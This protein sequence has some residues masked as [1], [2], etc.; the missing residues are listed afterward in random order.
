MSQL[1]SKY[2]G[3]NQPCFRLLE[4]VNGGCPRIAVSGLK[5]SALGFYASMLAEMLDR[6]IVVIA[7]T[8]DDAQEIYKELRFFYETGSDG[9]S[10]NPLV[11]MPP[12][13]T[14][15]YENVVSHCDISSERLWALYRLCDSPQPCTIVTCL[16]AVVQKMLPAEVLIDSCTTLVR[17]AE[18]DCDRLC[19]DF[20]SWG[21]SRVHM[22]EDRG[23]F[24]VRG[25]IV[26]VFPPGFGSPVRMDLYGDCIESIRLF[27]PATQRSREDIDRVT[28]VPV[29][30]IILSSQVLESFARRSAQPETAAVFASPRGK[31][32]AESIRS[33]FLPSGA[34]YCLPYLYDRLDS[35]FDYLPDTA[36]VVWDDC[37][38]TAGGLEALSSEIEQHYEAACRERRVAAPPD[39]MFLRAGDFRDLPGALQQVL[40]DSAPVQIPDEECVRFETRANEDLRAELLASDSQEG[41]LSR[42]AGRIDQWRADDVQVCFVCHTPSQCERLAQLLEGYGITADCDA[43]GLFRAVAERMPDGRIDICT[44][45]LSRGFRCEQTRLVLVTEEE[46]FGEKKRRIRAPRFRPGAT[47]SDFSDLQPGNYIVHRDS[48]IGV[49][50]GLETLEAGGSC[51][52]YLM[53]EYAGS[54]K[55]YL[56]VSRINLISRYEHADEGDPRLDKL[57]GSTWKRVKKRVRD[58]VEKIAND[59]IELY[60]ARKVYR[61]H[62]FSAPDH[63]YRE[64]EASF[65]YEETPDQLAA[66]RD[67]M[68]DMSD[69]MP[70]D[71]LICGDVGYGKTEIALRAAFRAAMDGKQ[72][73]V[74]VPTTVLAQQH[75][76]TF[77]ERLAPYPIRVDILSRFRSAADQKRIVQEIAAGTVEVIIGTHRLVSRDVSFK[78]LGLVVIDEEHRFGVTHKE[79]LKKLRKTVDVLTLTATPIPRTLQL[80]ML[81]VRDF[82][83]IETPPEDRLAIRTVITHFDDGVIRDAVERELK[84]G[85][86][87][88]F[89]HDRVRSIE[90]VGQYL[91]RLVPEMSLGI[92][93]G[94]MNEHELERSMMR[95][96]RRE[97]NLLLCTTIIESG[98]DFPTANTM[99]INNAHRLG[100]AQMY[101]LR[102]RV[103]RGKVRAYAYLLVP[104][105]SV[106]SRDAVK[107]LEAITEFS[108]LGSGYRLATRD[109]QI[110]GAGNILGHAQ[111]GQIASVGIDMYLELLQEAIVRCR[112]ETPAPRI[113]PEINLNIQAYLPEHYVPDTNQRLVLYRR[114]A[115]AVDSEEVTDIEDE[116]RDRFGPLPEPVA[117]LLE[118]AR[119]RIVLQAR[120]VTAVDAIDGEVVYSF[121]EGDGSAVDTMLAAVERDPQR[122]R[123]TPEGRLHAALSCTDERALL[124]EIAAILR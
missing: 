114:I 86:Q 98:L 87:I 3:R 74:F 2:F 89:V 106:M 73:A 83:T 32:F 56:P 36:V 69:P 97:T 4:L 72:V 18:I 33:G 21:Y 77:S 11:L 107:R 75:Y 67:V 104:A 105:S 99:I 111:S 44:G 30:E 22:V 118:T 42:L 57:G 34:E 116:V 90:A 41:M 45:D 85:G 115:S 13:E 84:R 48:G 113:D 92:A 27:D 124:Q 24:S 52:D 79:K 26:D 65:P 8:A 123:L 15:P 88:F 64:F 16:R 14:Q 17:G 60:S 101:Q 31:A 50:R 29:R 91:R 58:A 40:V 51:A 71:R 102:G 55:L 25:G 37:R 100:L 110:R 117:V 121:Y 94:Q 78:D 120:L 122:L 46:L 93:H 95:F 10:E 108:E 61:G 5:G 76:Q 23:D 54:D 43:D 96:V 47:I 1:V 38:S 82:S 53:L 103:G 81:G 80:S 119:L 9:A 35:L 12:L 62:A 70:M 19:A 63:Y 7:P 59:L 49:Y 6:H 39:G 68:R 28:I 109:L 66:I 112:G 20:V